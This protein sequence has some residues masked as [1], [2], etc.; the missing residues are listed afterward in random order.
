MRFNKVKTL[1][2]L[3]VTGL[4]LA[5]LSIWLTPAPAMAT[6]MANEVWN[7]TFDGTGGTGWVVGGGSSHTN[8]FEEGTF[9]G[10]SAFYS[11]HVTA[12]SYQII[13]AAHLGNGSATSGQPANKNGT[14][15]PGWYANGTKETYSLS[16]QYDISTGATGE[17]ELFYYNG[18]GAPAFSTTNTWEY[19]P[20]A[21]DSPNWVEVYDSGILT[22]TNAWE[23]VTV[24]TGTITG[25][26]PE[27]FSIVLLADPTDCT[28]AFDTIS[29]TTQ[30]GLAVA[31]EP[32]TMLLMGIGMA[33]AVF[34][35]RR[36]MKPAC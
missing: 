23:T 3:V 13:D 11:E 7:G 36:K 24:P 33:G 10:H 2:K 22:P 27:Y 1:T 6:V 31:P 21:V 15:N 9:N 19:A 29:L 30:S 35:R 28:T 12:D 34:V 4:A 17:F 5:A 20:N 16:Y 25:K 32:G 26:D 14:A 8:G 18:V